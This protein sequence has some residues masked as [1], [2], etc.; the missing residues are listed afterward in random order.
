MHLRGPDAERQ[1]A[2]SSV[3]R[4]VTV[5]ADYGGAG[6]GEPLLW[7]DDVH[8]SLASVVEAEV[9]KAEVLAQESEERARAAS[10]QHLDG[11][12]EGCAL[13]SAVSFLDE[14]REVGEI[15]AVIG[16]YV[17]VQGC[18]CAIRTAH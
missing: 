11:A 8:D 4:S 15:R 9:A 2:E 18:Q 3:S 6:E 12:L 7:P 10:G 5:A 13:C 1:G 17:V 14:A 16:R